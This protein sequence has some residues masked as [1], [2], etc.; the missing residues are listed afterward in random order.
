MTIKE[1]VAAAVSGIA[2]AF[3][4]G[5]ILLGNKKDETPAPTGETASE[6]TADTSAPVD[7]T[8]TTTDKD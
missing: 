5:K 4:A 3:V 8:G 2:G 6:T 7:T 1:A